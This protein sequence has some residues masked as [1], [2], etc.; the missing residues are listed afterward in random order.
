M[1]TYTYTFTNTYVYVYIY[2]TEAY[3]YTVYMYMYTKLGTNLLVRY[4][5]TVSNDRLSTI[6]SFIESL[7]H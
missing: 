2:G 5:V 7:D 4:F 3:A 1:H 6:V